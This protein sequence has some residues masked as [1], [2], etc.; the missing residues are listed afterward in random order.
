MKSK[1]ILLWH[2]NSSENNEVFLEGVFNTR[3]EAHHYLNK[4]SYKFSESTVFSVLY[5]PIE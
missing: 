4:V 1:W 2:L 3:D 5:I